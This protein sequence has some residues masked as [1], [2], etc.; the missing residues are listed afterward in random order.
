MA[1]GKPINAKNVTEL[2]DTISELHRQWNWRTLPQG[3]DEWPRVM[4]AVGELFFNNGVL[5]AAGLRLALRFGA[6]E[7]MKGAMD[8]ADWARELKYPD[9]LDELIAKGRVRR[10]P[11]V[12]PGA[13]PTDDKAADKHAK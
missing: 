5:I 8:E 7:E 9:G 4:E 12:S 11:G 3:P 6:I 1:K 13:W 2:A 10:P